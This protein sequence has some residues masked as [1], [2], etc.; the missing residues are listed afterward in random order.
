MIGG[1]YTDNMKLTLDE[2]LRKYFDE[3]YSWT[4]TDPYHYTQK[5]GGSEIIKSGL[6]R[7][8]THPALNKRNHGNSR[9]RVR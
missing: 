6:F 1:G 7:L 5:E 3:A 8:T 9:I 4:D 2:K